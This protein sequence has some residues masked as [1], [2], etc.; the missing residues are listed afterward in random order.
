MAT[1]SGLHTAETSRRHDPCNAALHVVPFPEVP[2]LTPDFLAASMVA[3]GLASS[4]LRDEAIRVPGLARRFAVFDRDGDGKLDCADV[5]AL[6][7]SLK[8]AARRAA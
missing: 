7:D 8:E 4:L 6:L 2:L 3:L 5:R 1:G